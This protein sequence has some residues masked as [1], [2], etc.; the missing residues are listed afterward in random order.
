MNFSIKKDGV[1]WVAAIS[2]ICFLIQIAISLKL[3]HVAEREFFMIP[4]FEA[5]PFDAG[6]LGNFALF[7][8]LIVNLLAV[9]FYQRQIIFANVLILLTLLFIQDITRIQAWSYQY[10]MTFAVLLYCWK[11]PKKEAI[12]L[13]QIMFVLTYVWSG[14]QK[15]NPHYAN[16][17]HAWLFSTYDWSKPF[18][19]SHQIGY[20]TAFAECLIGAALLFKRSRK[21]AVIGAIFMHLFILLM[22]GGAKWNQVIYP[23]NIG[24]AVMVWLLFWNL[25]F[26]FNFSEMRKNIMFW[27][28]AFLM[29]ICPVLFIFE[30]FPEPMSFAMYNGRTPTI[31]F[32]YN[33]VAKPNYPRGVQ[34]HVQPSK[35]GMRFLV[36]TWALE[37]LKV[38]AYHYG[39]YA[40]K[41]GKQMCQCFDNQGDSWV[42]IERLER[43]DHLFKLHFYIK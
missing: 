31:A 15:M 26:D 34:K 12:V 43:W 3:W 24:M 19:E 23:W 27:V 25:D 33:G 16:H 13:L 9:I 6:H 18:G 22:I 35:K 28:I 36:A 7:I 38:P 21:A 17:V 11:R 39:G 20:L 4:M 5:I 37:E 29:G 8:G 32:Y 40:Q 41:F 42:Q 30:K 1:Y 14:I 2:A 10:F